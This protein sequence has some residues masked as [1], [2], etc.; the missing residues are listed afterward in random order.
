[1]LQKN[2]LLTFENFVNYSMFSCTG[3]AF[4]NLEVNSNIFGSLQNFEKF[5]FYV[6]QTVGKNVFERRNVDGG[7]GLRFQSKFA[8]TAKPCVKL[9]A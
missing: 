2:Y 4:Q 3:F 8:K 1:M 9:H 5:S 7:S 6:Y